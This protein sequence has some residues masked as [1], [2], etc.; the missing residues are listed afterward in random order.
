MNL[1]ARRNGIGALPMLAGLVL[2]SAM[3]RLG[4]GTAGSLFDLLSEA[5][6][7]HASADPAADGDEA[8]ALLAA[9]E[10]RQAVLD[11]REAELDAKAGELAAAQEKLNA[12]MEEIR[13]AE[14]DLRE[15]LKLADSAAEDDLARLATVYQNMKPAEAAPLF[16]E[17]PPDFAAG[18]LAMMDPV[19]AAA[20]LARLPPDAGYAISVTLAGRYAALPKE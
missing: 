4:D 8:A 20:I 1:R 18:F 2:A 14:E 15:L 10:E 19:A 5:T 17:M 11:T 7:A 9:L 16:Q 12:T 13:I 6:T 3:L